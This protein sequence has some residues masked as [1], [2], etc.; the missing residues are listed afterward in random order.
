[1]R[2]QTFKRPHTSIQVLYGHIAVV[3]LAAALAVITSKYRRTVLVPD[4]VSSQCCDY[5]L[6]VYRSINFDRGP[7]HNG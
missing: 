7:P 1:M 3:V 2:S 6:I 5:R 4:A